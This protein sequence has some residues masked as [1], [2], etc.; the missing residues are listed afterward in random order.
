M[1]LRVLQSARSAVR[2]QVHRFRRWGSWALTM[3]RPWMQTPRSE[4]SRTLAIFK[5]QRRQGPACAEHRRGA[6]ASSERHAAC[7][8]CISVETLCSTQL[9]TT[10]TFSVATMLSGDASTRASRNAIVAADTCSVATTSSTCWPWTGTT[11]TA[12]G[13]R[14]CTTSTT[15]TSAEIMGALVV[16]DSCGRGQ[17]RRPVTSCE[18]IFLR[19]RL[20]S[21][22]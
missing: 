21:A 9:R 20:L 22:A 4:R 17:Q 1:R 15:A 5:P 2:M 3:G 19:C 10:R 8:P 14:S 11:V 6:T 13:T 18:L 16:A 12:R 7:V